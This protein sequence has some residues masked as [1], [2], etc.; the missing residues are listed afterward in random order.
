MSAYLFSGA[1]PLEADVLDGKLDEFHRY[2][3]KLY[4]INHQGFENNQFKGRSILHAAAQ[5]GHLELVKQLVENSEDKNPQDEHGTTPLH[6]AAEG[7]QLEVVKFLLPF[8]SDK[9]PKAGAQWDERTPL[10]AAALKGHLEIVKY[11]LPFLSDKNPKAGA[12]W[13]GATSL[14]SAASG[15]HLNVIQCGVFLH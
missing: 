4:N 2:A 12:R 1:P 3:D 5:K 8:L 9:N 14:H 15:G 6:N 10:H 13:N 11:L 7:G